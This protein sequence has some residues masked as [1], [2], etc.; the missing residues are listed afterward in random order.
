MA[1]GYIPLISEVKVYNRVE[2][3]VSQ[4]WNRNHTQK[5]KRSDKH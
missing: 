3:V 2:S 1:E 5:D 4:L